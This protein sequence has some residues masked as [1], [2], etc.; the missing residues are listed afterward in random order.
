MENPNSSRSDYRHSGLEGALMTLSF[1]PPMEV[2]L[3]SEIPALLVP[4]L[5]QKNMPRFSLTYVS[6]PILVQL[7][8]GAY[9][10]IEDLLWQ[11]V[12]A[13]L[14]LAMVRD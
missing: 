2:R 8:D 12:W 3:L 13:D 6:I 11:P 9:G 5:N 7:T 10:I 1:S 4:W 14:S